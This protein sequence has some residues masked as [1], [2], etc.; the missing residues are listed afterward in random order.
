MQILTRGVWVGARK[1]ALLTRPGV[2]ATNPISTAPAEALVHCSSSLMTTS[3]GFP[4]D[5]QLPICLLTYEPMVFPL[6]QPPH[7]V[8]G[9]GSQHSR[10]THTHTHTHTHPP[11]QGLCRPT[12]ASGPLQAFSLLPGRFC[13]PLSS[14]IEMPPAHSS[15]ESMTGRLAHSRFSE[16]SCREAECPGH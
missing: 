5:T 6:S 14:F 15:T 9:T 1:H 16:H 2:A 8:P 12:L 3:G 4:T 7:S 13:S 11:P 10:H